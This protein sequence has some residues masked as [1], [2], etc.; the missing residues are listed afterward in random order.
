[1]TGDTLQYPSISDPRNDYHHSNDLVGFIQYRTSQP[2]L[3][4]TGKSKKSRITLTEEK[5]D[6]VL[7]FNNVFTFPLLSRLNS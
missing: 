5:V 7:L 2:G 4:I 6:I 1:M 3:D